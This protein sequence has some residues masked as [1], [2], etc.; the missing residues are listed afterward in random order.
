MSTTD[1]KKM[2][3]IGV[4]FT[5]PLEFDL[6]LPVGNKKEIIE[7]ATYNVVSIEEV[8]GKK[9]YITDQWYKEYKRIPLIIAEDITEKYEPISRD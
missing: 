8:N 3:V 6:L 2:P 1:I 9:F 7:P 5:K 4:V